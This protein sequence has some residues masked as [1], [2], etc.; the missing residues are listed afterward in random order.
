MNIFKQLF[1]KHNY[2]HAYNLSLPLN[3]SWPCVAQYIEKCSKCAKEI[4]VSKV[5]GGK[6]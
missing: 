1:C 5:I 3:D 4:T 2:V 6:K